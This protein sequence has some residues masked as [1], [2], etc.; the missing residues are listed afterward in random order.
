MSPPFQK[1]G[2]KKKNLGMVARDATI[3]VFNFPKALLKRYT[4]KIFSKKR[5][6]N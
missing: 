3:V 1:L 6:T 5:G 2:E 4:R